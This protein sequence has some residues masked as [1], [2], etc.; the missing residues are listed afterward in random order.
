[1]PEIHR[2]SSVLTYAER[3]LLFRQS[4]SGQFIETGHRFGGPFARE[5]VG[6]G[7]ACGDFDND[8][9]L[10]LLVTNNGGPAE[11]LR[12]DSL[13]MQSSPRPHWLQLRLIG[14]PPNTDALGARVQVRA[15]ALIQRRTVHTGSSYL[16]QSMTRL[17][18]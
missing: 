18:F 3:P 9:D 5:E 7:A 17:H 11:L 1:Q 12:N 2:Q 16:S 15:G 4:S 8:G 10:D 6:R 14:S 13:P